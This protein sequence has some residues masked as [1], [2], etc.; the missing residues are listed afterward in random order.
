MWTLLFP[1]TC[2]GCGCLLRH[3]LA[4]ALC[5]RCGPEQARLPRS[6]SVRE[7]VR[8]AWSYDG[9]LARAVVSLKF[10][11]GLALAGP[12]GRL[13]AEDPW[14]RASPSG[15]PWD[16]ITA[17]PLHWRRRLARGFDQS[18]E[19]ARWAQRHGA[20]M[21]AAELQRVLTRRR[22]TTPQTEL[23]ADA[24]RVNVRG[25]FRVRTRARVSGRRVL[26][27]DDVTTT[28]AT[29]AACLEALREAGAGEVAGLA[30]LRR[31]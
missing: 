18:E 6:L 10:S 8:A 14:L 30:L 22:A 25:A 16:V 7:G 19:L 28:G 11:G 4:L 29:M 3:D 5:S 20:R 1:P 2:L 27:I 26:V 9:P 12:L 24:R 17:V 13:L 21:G 15:A 31:I 23:G